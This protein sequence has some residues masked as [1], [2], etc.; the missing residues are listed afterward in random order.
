[1]VRGF[2]EEDEAEA[3]A[4]EAVGREG[5]QLGGWR[6]GGRAGAA[7]EGG[8]L[9]GVKNCYCCGALRSSLRT[10]R[11]LRSSASLWGGL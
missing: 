7:W 5:D 9:E 6:A 1:M 3:R 10:S 11:A 2:L 8:A 4:E